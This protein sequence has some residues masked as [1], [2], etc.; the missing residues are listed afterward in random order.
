VVEEVVLRPSR[1][2]VTVPGAPGGGDRVS[3]QAPGRLPQPASGVGAGA[4]GR[5]GPSPPVVEVVEEV[6]LRPSRDPVTVPGAPGGGDRVSWQAP[7]RLPQPAWGVGAGAGGRGGRSATVS[8]PGTCAWGPGRWWRGF[9]TGARA[10]SSTSVGP[11]PSG[12]RGGRSATV[13]RPA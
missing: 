5:G 13:S 8:R 4:G 9:V 2:P 11:S 3:R 6:V 10:P 12:G 1:D 7:G